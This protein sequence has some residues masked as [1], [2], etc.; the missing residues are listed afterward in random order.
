MVHP[1]ATAVIIPTVAFFAID[2]AP[3]PRHRDTTSRVHIAI[4][5]LAIV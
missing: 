1:D 4:V 5:A 3:L 2:I